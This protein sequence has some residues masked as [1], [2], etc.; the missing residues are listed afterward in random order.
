M[1]IESAL[2]KGDAEL[3]SAI[4]EEQKRLLWQNRRQQSGLETWAAE[5]EGADLC[6]SNPSCE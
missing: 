5:A 1:F 3:A 2:L 4:T 6:Y